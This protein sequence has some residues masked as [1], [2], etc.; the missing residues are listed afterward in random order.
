V[1][2]REYYRHVQTGDRGYLI[3]PTIICLDRVPPVEQ[4]YREGEWKK[5]PGEVPLSDR[6]IGQIAFVADRAL[7]RALGLYAKARREW[8]TMGEEEQI[9]FTAKGPALPEV[10][11]DLFVAITALLRDQGVL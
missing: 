4:D 11:K 6:Q 7:C 2:E 5:E 9:H 10:R 8:N 3:S 1:S